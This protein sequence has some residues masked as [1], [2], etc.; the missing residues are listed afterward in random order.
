MERQRVVE[1][2]H[3]P[4]RRNYPRRHF[5]VRGF[6]ETWQA[7]LVEMQPY[8]RENKGFRYMLTVIDV[9]SKFAWAIPVK[10]KTGKDVTAAM[11]SILDK[12]RVPKN[13]NTDRGKEFY[14]SEFQNLMKKFNINLYSTYSNLKASICER[15]N[16]TLKSVMYKNFSLQGNY[17]WVDILPELISAYNNRKH[18]TLGAKPKDI[19]SSNA[20]KFMDR[21]KY[22]KQPV[23][24]NKFKLGDKVRISKQKHIF[25]KGYTPNWTTEIFTIDRV[26]ATSPV[27]YH[28]KDYKDEKLAGGF[29]EQEL[30]KVMYP[31]IYLIEKIVRRR[32]DQVFVKWLGF[33]N[34]HNSWINKSEIEKAVTKK[35]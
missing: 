34:T 15:F 8:S 3:K 32:G 10:S 28:L 2:L 22:K 13:L 19:T 24:K 30:Q 12:K 31:D 20:N 4:A 21:F 27:T 6:D 16:R 17:K 25:E 7:D 5:D 35:K 9:F 11:K 18:R 14:N 33:D 29:Y 23:K 1:E 26:A